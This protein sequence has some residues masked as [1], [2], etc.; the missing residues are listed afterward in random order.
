MKCSVNIEPKHSNYI[1][2]NGKF[3]AYLGESFH[4]VKKVTNSKHNLVLR[5]WPSFAA[6][7][8]QLGCPRVAAGFTSLY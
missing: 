1:S 3:C 8:N 2:F 6:G 5:F 4:F 7:I